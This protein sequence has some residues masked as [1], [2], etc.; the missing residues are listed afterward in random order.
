M[1]S[2]MRRSAQYALL[3]VLLLPLETPVPEGFMEKTLDRALATLTLREADRT[4]LAGVKAR[5]SDGAPLFEALA[6]CQAFDEEV[7]F[8]LRAT[9]VEYSIQRHALQTALNYLQ[10]FR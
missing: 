1:H 4:A 7:Q 3:S 10:Q 8:I 9:Q 2:P 5:L 6:S